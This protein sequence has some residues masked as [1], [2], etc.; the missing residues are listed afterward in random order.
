[1]QH[2]NELA[3]N[4]AVSGHASSPVCP[5]D[6]LGSDTANSQAS[7]SLNQLMN[8]RQHLSTCIESAGK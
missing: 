8:S 6:V 5:K 2:E 3:T 7:G 1:M 4:A